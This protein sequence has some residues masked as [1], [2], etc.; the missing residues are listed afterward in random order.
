MLK[1][2][3]EGA[4]QMIVWFRMGRNKKRRLVVVYQGS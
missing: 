4:V 1:A 2:V 3:M